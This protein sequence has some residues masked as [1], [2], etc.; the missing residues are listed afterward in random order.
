MKRHLVTAAIGGG[1]GGLLDAIYAT[2]TWGVILGLVA[3]KPIGIGLFAI[4]AAR[5]HLGKLPHS[6]HA[7]Q[8][9]GGG[10]LSGMVAVSA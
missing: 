10:A 3:G 2:V 8:I 1:I 9:M 6:L 4:A 5:L 7:G